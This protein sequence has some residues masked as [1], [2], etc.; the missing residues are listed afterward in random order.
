VKFIHQDIQGSTRTVTSLAGNVTARMDYQAFGEQI[1]NAIGQRTTT[2]FAGNDSIRHRY[3]FTE[4]DEATGLDDTWWRKHEN[5][6]G[7][8]TRPD[9]YN[10]SIST[11]NPQSLN[12]YSYV[13]NDPTNLVDPSGLAWQCT[14]VT[15]I[16]CDENGGNCQF[17]GSWTECHFTRDAN[18]G[19]SGGGANIFVNGGGGGGLPLMIDRKGSGGGRQGACERIKAQIEHRM[20][21]FDEEMAKYNPVSDFYGGHTYVRKDGFVG[22]TKPGGHYNKLQD[23]QK[24]LRNKIREWEKQCKNDRFGGPPVVPLP[25]GA[26]ARSNRVIDPPRLLRLTDILGPPPT[27]KQIEDWYSSPN[28]P[29]FPF[30]IRRFRFP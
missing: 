3:G 24:G 4:R 28:G 21:E 9:P 11:N 26:R 15:M 25:E 19:G 23:L 20:R 6:A 14:L 22:L 27:Q 5:R 7:R 16:I 30:S 13:I 12:R 18:P 1:P 29:I 2:G 17:E 8:W 10:G